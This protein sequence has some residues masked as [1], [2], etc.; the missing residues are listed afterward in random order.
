[1]QYPLI[2]EHFAQAQRIIAEQSQRGTIEFPTG[3]GFL[4]DFTGGMKRGEIWIIAG[5]AA[6]GK[7]AL[8]LQMA[9]NFA[10][11]PQNSILFLSLELKGWQLMLRMYCEMNSVDY[12]KLSN[13]R[14]DFDPFLVKSFENYIKNIDF[15]IIEG[16][17]IFLEVERI[18][19][20]YY[21]TKTPDIIFLDFIQLIEWKNFQEERLA[22]MEYIRKIKETANKTNI[23]FVIVSQLR[24]LP[25]GADYNRPPDLQDLMGSGSLEQMADKVL[26]IYKTITNPTEPQRNV[27]EKYFINLAKNRQGKTGTLPVLF[28][29]EYYRFKEENSFQNT[30]MAEKAKEFFNGQWIT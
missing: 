11:N 10:D 28:Q 22:L 25:S 12:S 18:I 1:M 6:A 26:F 27:E 21:E 14:I 3:L 24:R 7:T 5:K 9:R 2:S 4:D 13:N 15:E 29:G 30:P 8:A 16:G 23:G 17:Y 20:D 19:K